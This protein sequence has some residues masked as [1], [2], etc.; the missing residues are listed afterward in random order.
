[1]VYSPLYWYP[2][3]LTW[4]HQHVDPVQWKQLQFR[5][6]ELMFHN[7]M[8]TDLGEMTHIRTHI[9]PGY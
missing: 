5:G 2:I 9:L 7:C 6:I 4:S 8:R 1:M 3:I